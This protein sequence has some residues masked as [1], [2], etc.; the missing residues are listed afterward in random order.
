MPLD[1]FVDASRA[2]RTGSLHKYMPGLMRELGDGWTYDDTPVDGSVRVT[3]GRVTIKL[4]DV[5][6]GM[7]EVKAIMPD[8]FTPAP[9][10]SRLF[11]TP[12]W[13]IAQRILTETLPEYAQLTSEDE[14]HQEDEERW[15]HYAREAL[16]QVGVRLG[17]PARIEVNRDP[18]LSMTSIFPRSVGDSLRITAQPGAAPT[19]QINVPTLAQLDPY[20]DAFAGLADTPEPAEQV[21]A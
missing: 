12:P 6:R 20:V 19:L 3:N 4:D 16:T 15:E 18:G 5:G 1:T 14:Q 9:T 7:L 10:F 17:M 11:T 8:E 21:E 2:P 13:Q